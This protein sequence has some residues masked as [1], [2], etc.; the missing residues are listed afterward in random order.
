MEYLLRIRDA[1]MYI[2]CLCRCSTILEDLL[3]PSPDA[4]HAQTNAPQGKETDEQTL[5]MIDSSL[6]ILNLSRNGAFEVLKKARIVSSFHFI[7][8]I[9]NA[10]RF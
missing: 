1:S 5:M 2:I 4:E 8:R 9:A 3:L 7:Q 10:N 6:E